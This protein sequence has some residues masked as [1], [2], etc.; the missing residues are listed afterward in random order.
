MAAAVLMPTISFRDGSIHEDWQVLGRD[1]PKKKILVKQ[2]SMRHS[3]REISMDP[4]SVV[5]SLSMSPSLRRNDS[6]DM[7]L[8]RR[9]VTS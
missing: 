4:K 2:T 7:M 6:F 3:E 5:K 1:E 8:L 9:H